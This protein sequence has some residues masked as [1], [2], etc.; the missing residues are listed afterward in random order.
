VALGLLARPRGRAWRLSSTGRR[1]CQWSGRGNGGCRSEGRAA[2]LT[3]ALD[4]LVTPVSDEIQIRRYSAADAKPFHEAALESVADIHPWM[5]WCHHAFTLEEAQRWVESRE[6]L[7]VEG[8]EYSFVITDSPDRLLGA[9]DLNQINPV[10]RLAN[11]G[12]WV[13]TA[14]TGRDVAPAAIRQLAAFAFTHTELVRL[15]IVCAVGNIR[16]Q[17]A[18]EK[19]G[20]TREATLRDRLFL[21]GRPHDAVMYA[22]VRSSWSVV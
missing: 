22:I 7:F 14:A 8:R 2:P 9:C 13:R 12:Y 19:A 16:S 20:A 18:A 3:G 21:H 11:V 15:E 10:H 1:T 5:P 6:E 17:R 4:E